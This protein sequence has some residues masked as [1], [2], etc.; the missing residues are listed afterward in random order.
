MTTPTT[1]PDEPVTLPLGGGREHHVAARPAGAWLLLVVFLAGG[2]LMAYEIVGSRLLAPYFGSSTFVWGSLISVFLGALAAGYAVGGRLADRFP[3]AGAL[4]LV[5]AASSLLVGATVLLSAPLQEWIIDVNLGLRLDP[6]VS[7]V[8]L[9]GPASVLMG[10]VSPYAVRLRAGDLQSLGRTAGSLYGLSTFGS[11]AGTLAASFWLVQ[12]FGSE[13]TVLAVGV[14]LAACSVLTA[15]AGGARALVSTIASVS[16][17]L[18]ALLALAGAGG[19]EV[20]DRVRAAGS[21]YSPVFHAGGYKPEFEPSTGGTLRDK[22]DSSYHRIR[23]VDYPAG[24]VG[25]TPARVLHFD[26]SLQAAAALDA[27]GAPI[28]TGAP[29]FGYLRAFDL[30]PAIR[31]DAEKALLVGLGSGAAA[32]RLHELRPDLQIDVVEIDPKVVELARKWFGYRDSENGNDA[33][34][35]HVGDGR[36]WLAAQGDTTF[37]VIMLDTYFADSIPFHLTTREFLELVRDRLAPDGVVAA[38]LIGAVEGSRSELFRSMHR[39]WSRVFDDVAVYPVPTGSGV[40]LTAFSNIE[41]IAAP[42]RGVLPPRGGEA[43][44]VEQ[45]GFSAKE[46]VLDRQLRDLIAARYV[47]EV[48]HEGVPILT[49]DLAPVDSLLQVDGI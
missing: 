22:A 12:S 30:V 13:A 21:D 26:N 44:L 3:A 39:T 6:L 14:V 40:D 27:Q 18:V 48:D 33:I 1:P 43:T 34:T 23:V 25:D 32:M 28:T 24:Q 38:N 37:D 41:L 4:A 16:L 42:D 35:T 8:L 2:A 9:F 47:D 7:S 20:G 10:M 31:P 49:D 15:M 5:L 29:V 46:P 11:I 19:D 17:V 36:T 45:A